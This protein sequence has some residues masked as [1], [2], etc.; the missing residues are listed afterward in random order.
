MIGAFYARG[1]WL[2]LA[3]AMPIGPVNVEIIRRGLSRGFAAAFFLGLGACSA[4]M[5]YLSLVLLGV[6]QWARAG[7]FLPVL[8]AGGG[9]FLIALGVLAALSARRTSRQ[10]AARTADRAPARPLGRSYLTG[11]AMTLTNPMTIT[12]WVVASGQ[13]SGRAFAW[14]D[15]L[16]SLAGVASGTVG[17]VLSISLLC[18]GGRRFFGPRML[19]AVNLA[20]AVMLAGFGVWALLSAA[21]AKW[22]WMPGG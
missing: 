7:A 22:T 11:L 14:M 18:L 16:G 2:G 20:G 12:Y 1:V 5:I 21:G 13:L 10:A 9:A 3:A 8:Q 19:V 17:W 4:D 6:A 15:Y